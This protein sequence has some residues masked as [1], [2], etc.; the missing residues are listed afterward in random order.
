M[1]RTIIIFFE[2]FD[3]LLPVDHTITAAV[4]LSVIAFEVSIPSSMDDIIIATS[5][6]LLED[7]PCSFLQS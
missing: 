1:E 3:H 7:S 4:E 6:I 5:S 2:S